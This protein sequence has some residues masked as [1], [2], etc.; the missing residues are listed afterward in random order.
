M[1][2]DQITRERAA[3]EAE[4]LKRGNVQN[5]VLFSREKYGDQYDDQ[6]VQDA[7][8]GWCARAARIPEGYALVKI[9]ELTE[10]AK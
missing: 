8:E 6:S 2:E 9:S 7:F 5:D 10:E 4:W 1:T 3:F